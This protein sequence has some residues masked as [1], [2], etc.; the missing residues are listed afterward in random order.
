MHSF[1]LLF[2]RKVLHNRLLYDCCTIANHHRNLCLLP[3]HW[4]LFFH[5]FCDLDPLHPIQLI[6]W[7]FVSKDSNQNGPFGRSKNSDHLRDHQRNASD[8]NVCLGETFL[9]TSIRSKKVG[10]II[11]KANDAVVIR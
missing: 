4:K 7:T 11:M 5:R 10:H 6:Q 3:L 1:V 9:Q 8:Q 2:G